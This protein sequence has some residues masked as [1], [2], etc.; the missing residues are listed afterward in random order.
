LAVWNRLSR[1]GCG[2]RV[3]GW[4]RWQC[5]QRWRKTLRFS[6]LRLLL[7]IMYQ[8]RPEHGVKPANMRRLFSGVNFKVFLKDVDLAKEKWSAVR[9]SD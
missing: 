7:G 6:A 2:A 4:A 3:G 5:N 8:N 9:P 1:V